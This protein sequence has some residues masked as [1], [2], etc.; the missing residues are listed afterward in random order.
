MPYKDEVNEVGLASNEL[1]QI[2]WKEAGVGSES[3][4]R[5]GAGL[6]RGEEQGGGKDATR[7][8]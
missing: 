8:R 5:R 1:W 6:R 7:I 3:R 2:G 4:K